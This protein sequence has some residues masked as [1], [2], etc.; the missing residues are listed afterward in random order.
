MSSNQSDI[1]RRMG[2]AMLAALWFLPVLLLM[3]DG[4]LTEIEL[5][6]LYMDAINPDYA[7]VRLLHPELH[8]VVWSPPGNLYLDKFPILFQIYAG[9]L[10]YWFGLPFYAT[11][12]TN[13]VGIRITHGAFALALLLSLWL[14]LKA[15]GVRPWVATG[16]CCALAIDP[17]FLGLFRTQFYIL[18]LLGSLVFLSLTLM[19]GSHR[20]RWRVL[21]SGFFA[22][23]AAYGYFVYGFYAI[24]LGIILLVHRKVDA[25]I[26]I[27][28]VW[29]A[30]ALIGFLP[31][32]FGYILYV[33]AFGS[34]SAAL[35]SVPTQIDTLQVMHSSLGLLSRITYI[36]E[37]FELVIF[38]GGVRAMIFGEGSWDPYVAAKVVTL[39]FLPGVVFSVSEILGKPSA[40]LR[41]TAFL[42]IVPFFYGAVFGDRLWAH[43]FSIVL[44]LLYAGAA[45]ALEQILSVALPNFRLWPPVRLATVGMALIAL[46]LSNSL[47]A[48]EAARML[49]STGGIGLASDAI[50]RFSEAS[51]ANR[52]DTDYFFPDWGLLMPFAMLTGGAIPYHDDF[53][54]K[55]VASVLC[56]GRDVVVATIGEGGDRRLERLARSVPLHSQISTFNQRDGTPIIWQARWQATGDL[57]SGDQSSSRSSR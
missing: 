24:A 15:W 27:V 25:P 43:H 38:G 33:S 53:N 30:G 54:P 48:A 46:I 10:S 47:N 44:P 29:L 34:L 17:A 19:A 26:R 31:A 22:G 56:N 8:P 9:S 3:A 7:I 57:C 12:G 14:F 6:G 13:I 11:L 2:R 23:L 42:L 39:I 16:V 36:I 5:P 41:V 49:K 1:Q 35:E 28:R 51:M 55:I 45:F 18:A 40:G 37:C 21:F 20:S 52:D 32:I 4:T 50:N